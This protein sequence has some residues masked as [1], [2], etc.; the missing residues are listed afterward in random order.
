MDVKEFVKTTL[1]Q[2]AEAIDESND[3]FGGARRF[4]LSYEGAKTQKQAQQY[5]LIEFDIAVELRTT[6]ARKKSGGLKVAVIDA[7]AG[8][9]NEQTNSKISRIKFVI[10]DN[11]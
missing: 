11:H 3:E 10:M 4:Q 5:S 6:N 1:L 2:V 8:A 7:K 9:K